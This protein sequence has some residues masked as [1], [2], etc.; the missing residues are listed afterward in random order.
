MRIGVIGLSFA[1]RAGH[2]PNPRNKDLAREFERVV[3]LERSEGHEVLGSLQWELNLVS[4]SSRI[5][6]S[7]MNVVWGHRD[8]AQ[9]Q[10]E[11]ARCLGDLALQRS[12]ASARVASQRCRTLFS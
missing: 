2:E 9:D 7:V 8:G 10:G 4:M 12:A 6:D 5:K 1:L 3:E 11:L